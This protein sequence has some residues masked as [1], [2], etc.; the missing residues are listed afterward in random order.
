[1]VFR[2]TGHDSARFHH[3]LVR[4]PFL[5][6]FNEAARREYAALY[7]R[8]Q[9]LARS[10]EIATLAQLPSTL[11]DLLGIEPGQQ[12]ARSGLVITPVIGERTALPPIFVREQARGISFI[13]LNLEPLPTVAPTGQPLT[14]RADRDTRTFVAWRSGQ[15][16][17][18]EICSGAP[19]SF[20]DVSRRILI[21]GCTPQ[22]GS[23]W[24]ATITPTRTTPR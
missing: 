9:S 13:N 14:E 3:E 24:V 8:Y 20:E 1:V 4:V 22:A 16:T 21:A 12:A 18:A 23:P 17:A 6:Y 2:D 5:L 10:G 15:A 19:R 11:L 7:A